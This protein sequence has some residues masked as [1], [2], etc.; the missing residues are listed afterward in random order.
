MATWAK[1]KLLWQTMLGTTGSTLAAGST[2]SGDY[3]V[4]YLYNMLAGSWWKAANTTSPVYVTLDL[5][6]SVTATADY[7]VIYGHNLYT[8]GATVVLQY[9]TDNFA[10]DVNDAFTAFAATSDAVILKEFTAPAVKR[11][12]RL[13]IS[14]TL[15]A[16]P[17]MAL[18]IWG[19]KTE[20]DYASSEFDPHEQE[21]KVTV[22]RAH[23]GAV[24]GIHE[25]YVDRRLAFTIADADSDLYAKVKTWWD[26]HGRKQLFIAWETA[27]NPTDVWLMFP[28][29]QFRNPLKLGGARRDISLGFKGA[30]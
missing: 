9:S 23:G 20:L 13:K 4:D 17:Y 16:A 19:N 2:A 7:L 10:A 22:N 29:P 27:N 1:I 5:G 15:S 8:I 28:D 25:N 6:A 21:A 3:D 11:Y 18:C 24:A 30:V 14:G 12:W 26:T